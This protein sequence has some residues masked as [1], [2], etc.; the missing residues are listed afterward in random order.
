MDTPYIQCT[1]FPSRAKH[2]AKVHVWAGI[3][4]KGPTEIYIIEGKSMHRSTH[5][6]L[7][8]HW[9]HF[10]RALSLVVIS[11]C[12]TTTRSILHVMH[13]ATWRKWALTGGEHPWS[14]QISTQ[15]KT[16]G[17]NWKSTYEEKL[18]HAQSK[19]W[20]TELWNF[21][22][23][24]MNISARNYYIGHLRKVI[25]KMIETHGDATGYWIC[26]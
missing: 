2:P 22:R 4:Q 19:D 21:C 10:S 6:S 14:L 15:S 18:S 5:K 9:C 25:P 13:K 23:Q 1:Y 8:A 20:L 12:K 11:S 17:M 24:L 3:S 16:C 7:K 26:H